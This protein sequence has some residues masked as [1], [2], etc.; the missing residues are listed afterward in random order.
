MTH[1]ITIR[2][3][4]DYLDNNGYEVAQYTADSAAEVER[5]VAEAFATYE[6]AVWS[7][8][9]QTYAD[10]TVAVR[11]GNRVAHYCQG[12]NGSLLLV[13]EDYVGTCRDT[14]LHN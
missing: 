14:Y 1:T 10:V 4:A 8:V 6:Q 3:E 7:S 13:G 2:I 5:C 11:S 9:S 12:I